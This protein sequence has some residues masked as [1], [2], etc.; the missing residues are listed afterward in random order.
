MADSSQPRASLGGRLIQQAWPYRRHLAG[1][2]GLSLLAPPLALL[3]PVPL[4]LAVDNIIQG[5]PLPALLAAG[6]PMAVQQSPIL[7][8]LVTAL[9]LVAVVVLGQLVE[10]AAGSLTTYTSENFLRNFRGQL[11]HHI[12]RLPLTY[13]DA[14]GTA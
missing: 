1:L 2:L 6:L 14:R 11:F 13:H 4:K 3:T 5:H 7:L 8:L 12:Q 10:T 9:L